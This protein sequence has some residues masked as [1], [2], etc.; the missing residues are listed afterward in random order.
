[1]RQAATG[2]AA[3]GAV[4]REI[5]ALVLLEVRLPDTSGYELCRELRETFGQSLPIVFLSRD[6]TESSDQTAGFLVGADDYIAKPFAPDELLARVRRLLARPTLSRAGGGD[7][8][9]R[10]HEVLSLLA[11]GHSQREIASALSV[12]P[13]TVGKHIEHILSKLDVHTRTHAV[14]LALRNGLV[15]NGGSSA[16]APFPRAEPAAPA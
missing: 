3:L 11:E 9:P 15:E 6:R 4:H 7:L 5:P 16:R 14:A 13:R 1:M 8:T 12:S 2:E 10:E